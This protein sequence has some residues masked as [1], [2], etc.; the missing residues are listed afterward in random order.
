[1]AFSTNFRNWR[2]VAMAAL[3]SEAANTLQRETAFEKDF[4]DTVKSVFS[5]SDK[6][7]TVSSNSNKSAASV[8][9]S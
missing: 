3:V 8:Q 4:P 5:A 9:N 1:M 7:F 6:V 2:N